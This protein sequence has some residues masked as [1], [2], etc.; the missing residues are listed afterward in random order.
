[1]LY[2]FSGERAADCR[3][4][5]IGKPVAAIPNGPGSIDRLAWTRSVLCGIWAWRGAVVRRDQDNRRSPDR[6]SCHI[7]RRPRRERSEEH[8]SELQSL[9]RQSYDVF[10]L[11]KKKQID[12]TA[13]THYNENNN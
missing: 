6:R 9:M 4:R 11:K 3:A 10:C 8:T 2:S 12:I 5:A 1:M 7:R 13:T